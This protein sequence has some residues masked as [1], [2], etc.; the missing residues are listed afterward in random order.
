[1]TPPDLQTSHDDTI[2]KVT[3]DVAKGQLLSKPS[4]PRSTPEPAPAPA[5]GSLEGI[6]T[7][8]HT[9]SREGSSSNM[10]PSGKFTAASLSS[11]PP[12]PGSKSQQNDPAQGSG[13]P[14][15]ASQPPQH[16]SPL[17]DNPIETLTYTKPP[18]SSK[19]PVVYKPTPDLTSLVTTPIVTKPLIKLLQ[20]VL[21]VTV[22]QVQ[23]RRQTRRM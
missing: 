20:P 11:T 3:P 16:S 14:F 15:M 17:P 13:E 2:T 23:C 6:S 7:I 18:S 5:T 9:S 19:S 22:P 4:P 12:D 1:M 21:M 10:P 8:S